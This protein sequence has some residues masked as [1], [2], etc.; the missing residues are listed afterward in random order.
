[1]LDVQEH[2]IDPTIYR[3]PIKRR[4]RYDVR[5]EFPYSLPPGRFVLTW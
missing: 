4:V 1:M 3:P 5:P 2:R